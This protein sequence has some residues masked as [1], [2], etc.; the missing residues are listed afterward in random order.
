MKAVIYLRTSSGE[1]E[2]EN[3]EKECLELAQKLGYEVKEVLLERLSAFK[4]IDRPKYD[5][6]KEMAR[7][8]EI[9]AVIVWALDRWIRNRDTMLEDTTIL[10]TY[11][12][13]IHS[14][15][16]A[17]LEAINI[18]GPLGRTIQEFMLGLI[19]SLGEME[20]QRK[21]ERVK[22]ALRKKN[23]STYSY[24]GKKWGRKRISTQAK[25]KIIQLKKENPNITIREI[26]EKVT[27]A[28]KG[29]KTKNVS[30]GLVHKILKENIKELN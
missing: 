21:S 24:K 7:K 6:V 3:Q 10:K 15:K 19:A 20:S 17:W 28:G 30:K 27:Y 5:K 26:C 25:N 9:Q 4:Q 22:L 2:P 29:N 23:N 1:Q 14:V 12:C 16:E 8:R 11:G 13:K 18:E